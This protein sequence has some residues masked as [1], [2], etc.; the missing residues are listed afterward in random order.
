MYMIMS[1]LLLVS[2]FAFP[3]GEQV[4]HADDVSFNEQ[5]ATA[6][7][8]GNMGVNLPS[9]SA[10]EA[11]VDVFKWS[12]PF[13]GVG[14]DPT[15]MPLDENGWPNSDARAIL[16]D[17]QPSADDPDAM[18]RFPDISGAYR[19]SFKGQ[20][21]VTA[22]AGSNTYWWLEDEKYD[23]DT[24]TTTANLVIPPYD[25]TIHSKQYFLL[26]FNFTDTKKTADAETNTGIS[27]IK[28]I[29]PGYTEEDTFTKSF[30][31]ALAPFSTFRFFEWNLNLGS[32]EYCKS[33]IVNN[34][35]EQDVI[36]WAERRSKWNTQYPFGT[37]QPV[38]AWQD[39]IAWEY[40]VE[41]ANLTG[42]DA[43]INIPARASTNYIT[44]LA[45]FM[46]DNLKPGLHLY[47]ENSNEVWGG[48]TSPMEYNSDAACVEVT[49]KLCAAKSST[50]NSTNLNVPAAGQKAWNMRLYARRTM[51]ISNI[52]TAAFGEGSLNTT[53]RPVL[54]WQHVKPEE[55]SDML[56]WLNTNYG[57]P[58][59]Y[60]YGLASGMYLV[61]RDT[62]DKTD[63][64]A[65]DACFRNQFDTTYYL[66]SAVKTKATADSY[67]L[68][69]VA[70]E[71]GT[72]TS[73]KDESAAVI[74]ARIAAERDGKMTDLLKDF[75]NNW[76]SI[77]GG[78]FN[79][80]NL[81]AKASRYGSW[82]LIEEDFSRLDTPK[83]RAIYEL[84]ADPAAAPTNFKVKVGA[85]GIDLTWDGDVI[86]TNPNDPYKYTTYDVM[87][88]SSAEG[89]YELIKRGLTT[90]SYTD[91]DSSLALD[92]T[93]YYQVAAVNFGGKSVSDAME[94]T[95]NSD[96]YTGQLI[97]Y[98]P[99][100]YTAG[101]SS[102]DGLGGGTGWSGNWTAS[103]GSYVVTDENSLVYPYLVNQ[104]NH[105]I[106]NENK[107][108]S[109][110]RSFDLSAGG[111]F[112]A[113]LKTG[114]GV[115]KEGTVLWSSVVLRSDV[116]T[117]DNF[118]FKSLVGQ[119]HQ[120]KVEV[121][122][123]GGKEDGVRVWGAKLGST[124]LKS[125]IPIETGKPV[126]AVMKIEF[127]GTS[128]VSFY[129]NPSLSSDSEPAT[130]DLEA[131][132]TISGVVTRATI[133]ISKNSASIDEIRYGN[134]F[135]S[136]APASGVIPEDPPVFIVHPQSR[137]VS[138][139]STV[140]LNASA[141]GSAVISY[142]WLK[143]GVELE[144]ETGKMLTIKNFGAGDAG[145]YT[146][147]ATNPVDT[148]TSN[149]AVLTLGE[150]TGFLIAKT[151]Q[152]PVI[153]AFDSSVWSQAQS[154]NL[155][156]HVVIAG[157]ADHVTAA[158]HSGSVKAL[159]DDANLYLLYDIK[160]DILIS[161]SGG[162]DVELFLDRNNSK[163]AAYGPGDF[164]FI[165]AYDDSVGV[166]ET[167]HDAT[168]G[169]TYQSAD[170][171]G[172]YRI[173]AKIPWATID[174]VPSEGAYLG[175]DAASDDTDGYGRK[176]KVA[177]HTTDNDIWQ[178]PNLMGVAKLTAGDSTPDP[179]PDPETSLEAYIG[180]GFDLTLGLSGVTQDF[181]TLELNVQYDPAK[182]EFA[183]EPLNLPD[184]PDAMALAADAISVA[185]EN[186]GL[187][188]VGTAVMPN[189]TIH[190]I[191][192]KT[193]GGMIT[194]ADKLFTLHGTVKSGV[195]EG[196]TTVLL[197]DAVIT[198]GDDVSPA[199]GN[200]YV[201]ALKTRTVV[202]TTALA[203]LINTAQGVLNAAATGTL[204]G[205]YP[206]S[207]KTA[208]QNAISQAQ[209][210]LGQTTAD[211]DQID[212][213]VIALQ[214]ALNVFNGSVNVAELDKA[215]LTAKIGKAQAKYDGMVEGTKVTQ[216]TSGAKAAL[217][218]A[219]N[220]A[221]SV[222]GSA[223]SQQ[224]LDDAVTALESA[225]QTSGSQII[226]LVP[227]ETQITIKDLA[228][229]AKYYEMTREEANWGLYDTADIYG[230]GISIQVIA[231]VARLLLE[232]W[233]SQQ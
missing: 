18:S 228:L 119:S 129:F 104:G 85:S 7:V 205:Q 184:H 20:A 92:E 68:Q 56:A 52:F 66:G 94:I 141:E 231:K 191:A 172:G 97:A 71:G 186:P 214:Q 187:Q 152:A 39:S 98:E 192:M 227:G 107:L 46:K 91:T 216:Y 78:L 11:F 164:Q 217:Q 10:M 185:P 6:P 112:G 103:S 47:L 62:I 34:E 45:K 26:V 202:D 190:I 196:S 208:L 49:G 13:R 209:T 175:W 127:N 69:Y 139:A 168:T 153:G 126:L 64:T 70:Y 181:N 12:R 213:A 1:F 142:Q 121:G 203:D 16:F 5:W 93:Y 135:A 96:T 195:A 109:M 25:K 9:I 170:Q 221:T 102:G 197:A 60:L 55:F 100:N 116:D 147:K 159:W 8:I 36:D 120:S 136:V 124:V 77:G 59:N 89:P 160:D 158:D 111:L 179:D 29:K 148:A 58:A 118:S 73:G 4:A 19:L 174:L 173:E 200:S 21:T 137:T 128:R 22:N 183:T 2:L 143:D 131:D 145:T 14:T 115:G 87:R 201:I 61:C 67:N 150:F 31:D 199:G 51:E 37:A 224:D 63:P 79:Y 48:I 90:T 74:A 27:D 84:G 113:Y 72:S 133:D 125:S 144:G 41:L 178:Y 23:P 110:N 42:K 194:D 50:R 225:M 189:G 161:E 86:S 80:Y 210:A 156:N 215:A 229:L 75:L 44:E 162:D 33:A 76:A 169:V 101:A 15:F 82:G 163:Y 220:Q 222:L 88:A 232:D 193:G 30:L 166:Q 223:T 138:P 123:F 140:A 204:P 206:S 40:I 230:N 134:T 108:S 233:L 219:I 132:T 114:G 32:L 35:C 151:A 105:L 43:W 106:N 198:E 65:Y 155:S 167:K 207:A 226:T 38:I 154:Y 81:S 177:W 182:L 28:L 122:Y 54:A 53:I 95:L 117:D 130:A 171:T 99:F 83:T 165:F 188:I 176:S 17:Y 3:I 180:E 146:V 57:D 218:A 149:P 211:Q 212:Q 157:G 24:N